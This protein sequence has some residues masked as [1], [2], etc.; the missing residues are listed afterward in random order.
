MKY[1]I[2]CF[3]IGYFGTHH[4]PRGS[5]VQQA[6]A[7]RLMR[8]LLLIGAIFV[9]AFS[10]AIASNPADTTQLTASLDAL[11][12]WVGKE[13]NGDKW[14]KYLGSRTLRAQIEK[15]QAADPAIVSRVL[16]QYRTGATGL[17]KKRFTDVAR[18]IESWR[19]ALKQQYTGDLPKL[20]WA[21]RGDYQ[22]ANRE[23]RLAPSRTK[24]RQAAQALERALGKNS[25]FSEN[26]KRYLRWD[27]LEP[28]LAGDV[29]INEQSLSDLTAVL[30]RFRSNVSGLE[31]PV[32]TQTAEAIDHYRGLLQWFYRVE[33]V[34]R[35]SRKKYSAR[36]LER[37]VYMMQLLELEKQLARHLEQ[38]SIETSRKIGQLLGLV[39]QL[40]QS[41]QL[42]KAVRSRFTQPN[43][44]TEVAE[45]AI[46]RLAE[47]PIN[48]TQRVRDCILGA[49]I[50]GTAHSKGFVTLRTLQADDHIALELQL[51]GT[52]RSNTVGHKKPV[53]ITSR[54]HTGF[55]A[56]KRVQ[57]SDS[58]FV[59]IPA[60]VSA[61]TKTHT[62]AVK[63]AGGRF[64]H[65]LIE[66]IAWKKV[67]KSKGK[68]ERIASRKAE[69]KVAKKFDDQI[70]DTIDQARDTYDHKARPPLVRTGVFPDYLLMAST[71]HS[72]HVEATLAS[73]AQV[74]ASTSPISV[75]EN[76]L[77]L[78]FHETAVNNFLPSILAGVGI[79]QETESEPPS[80]IGDF[81]PW[82]E[83]LAKKHV[84]K[85]K[86]GEDAD[87]A[88][89]GAMEFK[90]F[91]VLLNSTH[92]L[93]VKFDDQRITLRI[94]IAELKT[95]EEG[96][97]QIR[98][99]WDFIL[100]FEVI[101]SD[102]GIILRR[103]GDIEA[104]PTGFDP[105]PIWGDKLTGKQAATRGALVKVLRKRADSEKEFPKEISI[106]PLQF[107]TRAGVEYSLDLQ[108]LDCD[109]GWLTLGYQ[110]P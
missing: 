5:S 61:R 11:D 72:I 21:S 25:Q 85:A 98:E 35:R 103:T 45:S 88:E 43:L 39:E 24:L 59:A 79:K 93:S 17:D 70:A 44:F 1:G 81:P 48:E 47:R 22:P 15:G 26:W 8:H 55:V 40:D 67:G 58:S 33:G 12:H 54:G 80:L 50:L 82:L 66:R 23:E 108:H 96:E 73:Y 94:R 6:A 30:K 32:F 27:R 105:T 49:R 97:E 37:R 71:D 18:E 9:S 20:A 76:D 64:G 56:T 3:V 84:G 74:S 68:S 34:A 31:N 95:I 91:S 41:P 16:E 87:V 77:S 110:L 42:V 14:R 13:A 4:L 90:P 65:R 52:I 29:T 109:N 75:A 99:N 2:T 62:I 63:K 46:N 102:N 101:Q 106:P 36:D 19:D 57:I 78:K 51:E 10:S 69:Q 92:P 60:T 7:V 107:T 83:D 100:T 89:D 104:F 28:H 86:D 38:P 53:R